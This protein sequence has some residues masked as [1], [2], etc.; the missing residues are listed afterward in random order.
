MDFKTKQTVG[1]AIQEALCVQDIMDEV[2]NAITEN[3]KPEDVFDESALQ[4][5]ADRKGYVLGE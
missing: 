4:D 1:K 5:W 3:C 2:I